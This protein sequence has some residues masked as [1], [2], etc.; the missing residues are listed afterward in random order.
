VTWDGPL[1]EVLDG[2]ARP[3][4]EDVLAAVLQSRPWFSG[5]YRTVQ[6]TEILEVLPITDTSRLLLVHAEYTEG[7]AETY[8][9]PVA[10]ASG[11]AAEDLAA[12]SPQ[13][14][15]ATVG[16]EGATAGLLY[17]AVWD[18]GF[19]EGLLAAM[20]R[21]TVRGFAGEL[22]GWTIKEI[23]RTRT[24][25]PGGASANLTVH[26]QSD[27]T[28]AFG[29]RF[30]MRL[31]RRL[32]EGLHPDVEVSRFLT[33][34]GFSHTPP[35]QGSLDYRRPGGTP[36]TV[37]LLHG[38]VAREG[39]AWRLTLDELGRYFERVLIR[40]P[41]EPPAPPV[42]AGDLVDLA[43][44]EI[45]H[46]AR[47]A[48]GPF[49]DSIALLGQRTAELHQALAAD[50]TDPDFA[51]ETF[52][53]L[54]QRSLVHSVRN[55]A[56]QVQQ[57][58]RRRLKHLPEDARP[59]A[60]RLVS[61]EAELLRKL[62]GLFEKRWTVTRMRYHGSF[63]LGQV[64]YTGRDF[65]FA[66]S[67]GERFRSLADRRVK[68]AAIRDVASMVRSIH[69]AAAHVFS[70][71]A[72]SGSVRKEDLPA[73]LPWA[74]Y[75]RTWVSAAFLKSYLEV[76]GK[77]SFVPASTEELRTALTGFLLEKALHELGFEL[78][79]RPDWARIPLRGI[80]EL[81]GE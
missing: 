18:R 34:R 77:A 67:E 17:D 13:S 7:E 42:A 6:R 73:L 65:I 5:R 32:E 15:L 4:V 2:S 19:C 21:R 36:M 78:E 71:N 68:R 75:W 81:L 39:D 55:L 51:P 30:V 72:S 12:Q 22:D 45:P 76:A 25:A 74:T 52:S 44:G 64:L 10:W 58:L 66:L 31:L 24:P 47:E 35:L 69:Y 53:A 27:T 41:G 60:Q 9:L 8:L 29:N 57:R 79:G 40:A 80:L 48:V 50:A 26:D 23:R 33:D 14:L 3:L 1:D 63:H 11:K 59:D 20:T 54:Y 37:A 43:R 61:L 28:V 70:T 38:Y 62:R 16:R 56:R 46:E 49:L